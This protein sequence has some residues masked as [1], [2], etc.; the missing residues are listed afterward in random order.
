MNDL[1][2]HGFR[3]GGIGGDP[4]QLAE[5]LV[6]HALAG[7]QRAGDDEPLLVIDDIT[8]PAGSLASALVGIAPR[9]VARVDVL[10]DAGATAVYGSRGANGVIIIT[11]KRPR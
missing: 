7:R 6:P 10:K 1:V 2:Q 4:E 3:C 5:I 8:I 9:D 11:T